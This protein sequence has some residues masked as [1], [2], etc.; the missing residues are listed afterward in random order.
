MIASDTHDPAPLVFCA[1]GNGY[2]TDWQCKKQ[3]D[4]L[5]FVDVASQSLFAKRLGCV[6][7]QNVL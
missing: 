5:L 6:I 7:S 3:G 1:R 4:N 2:I